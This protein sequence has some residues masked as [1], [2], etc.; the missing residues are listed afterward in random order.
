MSR[1]LVVFVAACSGQETFPEGAL[2][3]LESLRSTFNGVEGV[4]AGSNEAVKAVSAAAAR[5]LVERVAQERD[6]ASKS[7]EVYEHAR[8][9]VVKFKY[10]GGCPRDMHGCPSGWSAGSV[11][12]CAPTGAYTGP[13]VETDL[14]AYTTSEKETFAIDCRA[15]WPC[16]ACM[17]SFVGCPTDWVEVGT[18]CLAPATYDG[19]CSTVM[20]FGSFSTGQKAR[21]SAMCNA[22]WPCS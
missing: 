20:N 16:T 3:I 14:S 11:G 5:D 15:S 4:H 8:A 9:A 12:I 1:L 6:S 10:V 21:W 13:C 2:N 7:Q 17:T 18:L 19:I 22:K